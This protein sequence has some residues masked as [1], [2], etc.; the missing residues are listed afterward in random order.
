M[1]WFYKRDQQ[2][3]SLETRYDNER[4]EFV[5]TLIGVG[6]Q[7][8]TKRFATADPFRE[9]LESME[10]DLAAQNWQADG[11]PHMLPDGWRDKPWSL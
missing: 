6:S 5:G 8:I 1:V 3:L 2:S 10:R 4:H 9:W 11:S 7:P